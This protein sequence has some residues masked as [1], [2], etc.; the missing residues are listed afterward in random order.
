L[1]ELPEG[2]DL[3]AGKAGC[4]N[5]LRYEGAPEGN[6]PKGC[7]WRRRSWKR[8][9]KKSTWEVM[10][11]PGQAVPQPKRIKKGHEGGG[12]QKIGVVEKTI[13]GF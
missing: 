13:G 8:S 11:G 5:H 3:E 9:E 6:K 10:G 1:G 7:L 12:P 2:G 4:P